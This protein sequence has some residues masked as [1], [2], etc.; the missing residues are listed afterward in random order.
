LRLRDRTEP[1]GFRDDCSK[2][3]VRM[4]SGYI[5]ARSGP[6][7]WYIVAV[8]CSVY[9]LMAIDRDVMRVLQ[10]PIQKSLNLTDTE[11]GLLTGI[12][13]A[14]FYATMAIPVARVAEHVNRSRM[15]AVCIGIWSTMTCF[16][17]LAA[18]FPLLF[19]CRVAVGFGEAGTYP[20]SSSVAAD[21]FPKSERALALAVFAIGLS[22]GGI[23]GPALAG[24]LSYYFGWRQAFIALGLVGLV[25]VPLV[26]FTVR[27]PKRGALDDDA[28]KTLRAT[29]PSFLRCLTIMWRTKSFRYMIYAVGLHAGVWGGLAAWTAPYLSRMFHFTLAELGIL[30][31][32]LLGGGG[33]LGNL[34]SGFACD[35]L[36][37]RDP[38]WFAFIPGIASLL[39]IP[40]GLLQFY[41]G[42][43]TLAIAAG[44]V[45]IFWLTVF[46]P[47]NITLTQNLMVP[48]MRATAASISL[49][50][51][52]L[53]GSAGPFV[54]GFV[55][56]YAFRRGAD[57]VQSVRYGIVVLLAVEIV[58]AFY[59]WKCATHLRADFIR[60]RSL[61]AGEPDILEDAI[62]A[63]SAVEL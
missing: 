34:A 14:L 5:P 57:N 46:A 48:Q 28:D 9:A 61:D 60:D 29:P 54:V 20:I 25:W 35:R 3:P 24:T 55:S 8:M 30:I 51:T 63:S 43:S 4:R 10:V 33:M 18:S 22:L 27:D 23:I 37:R 40:F 19:L 59:F 13:Y 44:V 15:I 50:A 32:L 49:L 17:G 42:N 52:S 12:A 16:C 41:L 45:T 7:R 58:A 11:L 36:G 47:P 31:G 1:K 56:D 21:Y 39:V 6:Y 53:L 26:L 2:W 38:R 62:K